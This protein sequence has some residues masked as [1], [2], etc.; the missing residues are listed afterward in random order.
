MATKK[1]STIVGVF[2][3]PSHAQQAIRDLKEAGF[4]DD[5]LGVVSHDKTAA[6][7]TKAKESKGSHVAEGAVAGVAAGAG[8]GALWALGIAASILPGIGPVIAGGL[9]ASVLASAAGGAAIAGVV[10]ALVGLGIPEEEAQYYEG[11]FKAGRTIVTV[12]ANG[13]AD[14]AWSILY[15]HGAYNKQTPST[16]APAAGTARSETGQTMKVH[17]EQLR[18]SKTP[19]TTGE[20]RVR[21]EVVTENQTLQVPVTREE[22][23]IQRRP[24][25]GGASTGNIKAGEEVRIPVKEEQVRVGKETVVKEEVSVG[26]RKV[27]GTETVSGTVRKERV[28]VEKE[29]DVNLR[30]DDA[31]KKGRK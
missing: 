15:S 21:K 22:V 2:H 17:E 18:A 16:A 10:G 31:G 14:E 29:G 30:G 27:T 13:H 23:V 4:R 3:D 28:K 8:V 20:V 24:A 7:T 9:L 11:E 12:K 25:S 19:V 6:K 26:K 1:R 5:Q